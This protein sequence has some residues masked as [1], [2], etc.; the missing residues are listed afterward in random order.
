MVY[1][2]VLIQSAVWKFSNFPATHILCE[3]NLLREF[4]VSE[5]ANLKGSAPLKFGFSEFCILS[6]LKLLKHQFLRLQIVLKIAIT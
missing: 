5:S 1:L 2:Q 6:G 3:I 4:R